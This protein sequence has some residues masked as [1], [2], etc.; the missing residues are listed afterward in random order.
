MY[1]EPSS[2][3]SLSFT[4]EW[5][6]N[7]NDSVYEIDDLYL[8]TLTALVKLTTI[9]IQILTGKNVS[10]SVP[11]FFCGWLIQY[12]GVLRNRLH[13]YVVRERE[14]ERERDRRMWK[15]KRKRKMREDTCISIKLSY[16]TFS[17]FRISLIQDIRTTHVILLCMYSKPI[18]NS[19]STAIFS[20]KKWDTFEMHPLAFL[21]LTNTF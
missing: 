16:K 15:E 2:P 5:G 3:R 1:V 7:N 17:R 9:T 8:S 19:Q 13:A 6:S 10:I 4:A 14:R 20:R 11:W 21:T 12:W 18:Q